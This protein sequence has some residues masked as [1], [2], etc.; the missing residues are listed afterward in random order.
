MYVPARAAFGSSVCASAAGAGVN[1]RARAY[2]ARVC[3]RRKP[4]PAGSEC[5]PTEAAYY[6]LTAKQ[7]TSPSVKVYA[8]VWKLL[9][10]I[11]DKKVDSQYCVICVAYLDCTLCS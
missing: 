9:N 11:A 4:I 1:V 2:A 3:V 6:F 10:Q 8:P 7:P 5:S